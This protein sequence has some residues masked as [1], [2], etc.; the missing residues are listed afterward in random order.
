MQWGT[1]EEC[2]KVSQAEET[3]CS[4]WQE[5]LLKGLCLDHSFCVGRAWMKDEAGQA[6]ADQIVEVCRSLIKRFDFVLKGN[7]SYERILRW[8][9]I[10]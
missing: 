10:W 6:E 3:T 2:Q 8:K 9:V 4:R 7:R 1:T 5:T